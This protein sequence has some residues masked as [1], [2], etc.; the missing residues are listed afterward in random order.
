MPAS[1][2]MMPHGDDRYDSYW[3]SAASAVLHLTFLLLALMQ[4]SGASGGVNNSASSGRA[5]V[6]SFDPAE[7][8]R[9]RIN[10]TSLSEAAN[11]SSTT[12]TETSVPTSHKPREVDVLEPDS[13]QTA[14]SS[15]HRKDD[16]P[17]L[18][19]ATAAPTQST[20]TS[21]SGPSDPTEQGGSSRDSG[22]QDAY[23]AAVRSAILTTWGKTGIDLKGCV[24]HVQQKTG[25]TVQ[26]ARVDGCVLDAAVRDELEAAAL[27]A[28]PLP[29][30]GYEAVFSE[31]LGLDLK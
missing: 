16:G 24:L 9:Q 14:T 13:A 21:V 20:T 8:F 3:A 27:M 15:G 26:A 10:L 11:K 22:L 4:V 23:L 17:L 6:V 5:L 29:Y 28:Q 31:Q 12:P 2:D 19:D 7:E 1:Q 30:A 18:I 25:G